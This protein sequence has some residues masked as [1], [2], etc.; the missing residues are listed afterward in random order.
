MYCIVDGCKNLIFVKKMCQKHYTRQY[1]YGSVDFFKQN[2]NQNHKCLIDDCLEKPLSKNLCRSH[3]ARWKRNGDNFDKSAPIRK[4]TK[5]SKN[6]LCFMPGCL[7]K[8][9]SK[10][11]CRKHYQ[12]QSRHKIRF[13]DILSD[14]E[15]GCSV[16]RTKE[17]LCLDHDHSICKEKSVC[18]KCYRGVLCR[19]CNFAIGQVGE[20]P[21]RLRS[22]AKYIESH[23]K[24]Q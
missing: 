12:H 4:I 11:F 6:D 16:C 22:L 9:K 15:A 3:Y 17:N 14:L 21:E 19:D 23:S 18:G 2:K 13:I 1:R 7:E 20:N 10:N 24:K 5:Y 8:A